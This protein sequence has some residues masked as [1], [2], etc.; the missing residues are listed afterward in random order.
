V[1]FTIAWLD[2]S[3]EEQRKVREVVQLFSQSETQ[4]ELGGRRVVVALADALFP[5]TSVL[6]SRA[7][8][9][10]FVPWL[11][12]AAAG[13]RRKDPRAS[14]DYFERLL[15]TRFIE[16]GETDGL[17]GSFAGARVKQLP[18]AAYW[19]ALQAWG[20]L[21]VPGT[22]EQTLARDRASRGAGEDDLDE[23]A[24]RRQV[25]WDAGA[26][27]LPKGFPDSDIAGGFALTPDEAAWLRDRLMLSTE[28]SMLEHLVRQAQPLGDSPT[29]WEEPACQS[30]TSALLEVLDQAE[31]FAIAA[32]GARLLYGLLVA[33]AYDEAGFTAVDVD[34]DWY[35]GLLTDWV[36]R[37]R[38]RAS[39][40]EGW[41]SASFWT[42]VRTQNPRIDE[43]ARRFFD[44]WFGVIQRDD[45][46]GLADQSA[47]R[48][49][50]CDRERLLKKN[51]A[52]LSNPRLLGGWKG[53][54]AAPV[55]YRWR[56]VHRLVSDVVEGLA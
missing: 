4:D 30:G 53:G 55:D 28:G 22:V 40:F 19:T 34:R 41:D 33:E 21:R 8:Y 27:Q 1:T 3:A 43:L 24:E 56:Q 48:D 47:M 42:F 52:R 38:S 46:N 9:L 51:Q 45:L 39:L 18:S 37:A 54:V 35:R 14:L 25:I 31:R 7:R 23:L 16:S 26:A 17:I 11:C 49:L 6:H 20:I 12:Q 2:A 5:G 50:V 15:I 13:P 29:P 44:T 36:D 10:L 32:D